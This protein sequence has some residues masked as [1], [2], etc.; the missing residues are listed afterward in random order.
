[1]AENPLKIVESGPKKENWVSDK[2]NPRQEAI[3]K[4]NR[5]W[6]INPEQFDPMRNSMEKIR[7]ERTVSLFPDLKGKRAADLGCGSGVL[8]RLIRD[9]GASVDAVDVATN[10]L[11]ELEKSN[12]SGITPLQDYVPRT[13]LSDDTYD[14]VIAAELV[15]YLPVDEYRLFMSELARIV[16]PGAKVI[17]STPI[18]IYSTDSL[19]RFINLSETEFQ[20]DEWKLSYHKYWI[21][22]NDLL[23][24]PL[25]FAHAGSDADYRNLKIQERNG[26]TKTWFR[27][28]SARPICYLWKVVS[29]ISG[30]IHSLYK[31]SRFILIS[32]EKICKAIASQ[33]GI[34][35]AIWIGVRRPLVEYTP[36]SEQPKVHLGKKQVWE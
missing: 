18:D 10:A 28:N 35:H 29:L 2:K 19:E 30:P 3:A 7:I 5:L 16:K 21:K 33:T 13:K 9:H 27:W 6:L 12:C 24:A 17:C 31:N 8:S 15:A 23:D 25:R 22:L 1:M 32:L 34:S 14:L 4:F 11:K 20:P 36:P 26:F